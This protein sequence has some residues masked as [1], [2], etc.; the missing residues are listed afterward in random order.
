MQ[1]KFLKVPILY[2][3]P[4]NQ[5]IMTQNMTGD[6]HSIKCPENIIKL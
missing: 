4:D 1:T 2:F 3:L 6:T 5:T